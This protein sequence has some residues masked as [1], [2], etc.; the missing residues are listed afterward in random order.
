VTGPDRLAP[1]LAELDR[2]NLDDLAMVALPEPDAAARADLL[3]QA[4]DAAAAAGPER[5]EEVRAAPARARDTLVGAYSR[6]GYDPSWFG[7]MWGRSIGRADDRARLIAAVEDAAV[8]EI[9]ADLLPDDAVAALCE[10][11]ALASSLPGTAPSPNPR[12]GSRPAAGAVAAIGVVTWLIGIGPI[13][14]GIVGGIL[15]RR[16]RRE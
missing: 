7:L 2:L 6:R 1:F 10:G 8:A 12:L 15:A 4:L 16:R 13:V 14:I 5:L 9:V 3:Q 11:F